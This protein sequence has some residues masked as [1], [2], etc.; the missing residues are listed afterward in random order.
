MINATRESHS[1]AIVRSNS[2]SPTAQTVEIERVR[3]RHAFPPSGAASQTA[4]A[5]FE[6]E[7]LCWLREMERFDRF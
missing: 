7:A 6:R 4:N 3:L 1:Q 5:N 2:M